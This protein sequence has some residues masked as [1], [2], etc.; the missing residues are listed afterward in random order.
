[1]LGPVAA[2]LWGTVLPAFGHLP[3][4]GLTGPSLDPFRDLIAWAGLPRA[5]FLSLSTGLLATVISLAIVILVTA[6][7]SGT[8]PFR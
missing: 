6:G 7:W 8:R 4:A 5:V 2:G 1:M 3:A